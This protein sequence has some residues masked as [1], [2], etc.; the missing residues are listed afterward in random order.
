MLLISDEAPHENFIFQGFFGL[1]H[2]VKSHRL[3]RLNDNDYG[4]CFGLSKEQYI[5]MVP[6]TRIKVTNRTNRQF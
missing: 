4:L 6:T 5:A 2:S 1:L 3:D